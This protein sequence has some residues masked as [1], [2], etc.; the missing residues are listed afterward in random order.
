VGRLAFEK[1]EGGPDLVPADKVAQV[2]AGA[3]VP[4]V[5]LNACQSASLGSE[6]EA[7]VATRLPSEGAA[8]VVAMAYSVY[9]VAASEFMAAFYERLF[10]GDRVAEAVSAGRRRLAL[11]AERPSPKGPMALADWVVPVLYTRREVSF[12]G[13]RTERSAEVS[14]DAVLDRIQQRP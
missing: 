2:L 8:A 14:L 11:R 10:A 7:A 4:M 1:P 13:L 12:P 6:I 5:V 3:Q 9:A